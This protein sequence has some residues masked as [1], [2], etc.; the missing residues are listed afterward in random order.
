MKPK[1]F[2]SILQTW[3]D[4]KSK[5]R[6]TPW[7]RSASSAEKSF[8][9]KTTTLEQ[10]CEYNTD[11]YSDILTYLN[12]AEQRALVFVR[13]YLIWSYYLEKHRFE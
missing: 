6:R 5:P 11:T 8:K 12:A 4:P 13:E 3:M 2:G 1:K 10:V 7:H 9:A